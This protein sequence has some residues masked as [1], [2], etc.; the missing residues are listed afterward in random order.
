MGSPLAAKA[1]A[2]GKE[3]RSGMRAPMD[4]VLTRRLAMD[5]RE[6]GMTRL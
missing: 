5:L 1:E 6:L 3:N 2:M 4:V